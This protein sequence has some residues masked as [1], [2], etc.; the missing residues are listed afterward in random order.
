MTKAAPPHDK[1]G[2]PASDA[3]HDIDPLELLKQHPVLGLLPPDALID[4]LA[5]SAPFALAERRTVL[6]E[7]DLADAVFF[8]LQGVVRVYHRWDDDEELLLKLFVPP[9]MFGEAE[10]LGGSTCYLEFARTVTACR[11]LRIKAATFK[12]LLEKYPHFARHMLHDMAQRFCLSIKLEKNLAFDVLQ[13]RLARLLLDYA[14]AFPVTESGSSSGPPCV[15][16]TQAAIAR[17]LAVS[18]QH[19]IHGLR[20]LVALK[21]IAYENKRY[22]LLDIGGLARLAGSATSFIF[23]STRPSRA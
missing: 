2:A 18:R 21:L 12:A 9:A 15:D 22:V 4:V 17:D 11:L 14:S 3:E 19:T 13:P 16:L 20:A 10:I 5:G 7:G 8:L 1:T 23:T 6:R